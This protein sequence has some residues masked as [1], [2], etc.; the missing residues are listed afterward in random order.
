MQTPRAATV[1]NRVRRPVVLSDSKGGYLRNQVYHPKDRQIIWWNKSGENIHQRLHWLEEN[2]GNKITELGDIHLY[3]WLGT[4]DLT[5]KNKDGTISL[6]SQHPEAV[7]NIFTKLQKFQQVL[8]LYPHSKITFIETPYYSITKWND[9]TK[10]S[11]SNDRIEQDKELYHQ[12][13]NLNS[14]VHELNTSLNVHSPLLNLHLKAS[15]QVKRGKDKPRKHYNNYQLYIDGIHP[16]P[17]LA[18]AWLA[19]LSEQIQKDCWN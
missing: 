18:K 10:K 19:E 5:S 14:R 13:E 8:Q 15:K 9:R 2:I 16:K 4:C 17:L 12:I 3:I 6:A 1:G 7:E 11:Q